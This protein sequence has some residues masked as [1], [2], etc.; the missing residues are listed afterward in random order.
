MEGFKELSVKID[1]L[2]ERQSKLITM[3]ELSNQAAAFHKASLDAA[4]E[5]IREHDDAINSLLTAE[6]ENKKA[7]KAVWLAAV[8]LAGM[9]LISA[10]DTFSER[11]ISPAKADQREP[12]GNHEDH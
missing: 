12:R 3:I 4:H 11:I 8:S 1:L 10:W 5:H 2:M 6:S 9:F 7:R